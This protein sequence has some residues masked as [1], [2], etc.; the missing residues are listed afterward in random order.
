M[1]QKKVFI[2]KDGV[3]VFVH[4]TESHPHRWDLVEEVVRQITIGDRVFV[5]ETIDLGRI[6]GVDHLVETSEKDEPNIF[7]KERRKG[8]NFKSRMVK[9]R[10]AEPTSLASVIIAKC[11]DNDGPEWTG[12]YVLVTLFEGD[13]GMSE[14]YGRYEH[15]EDCINFWKTHALVPE[16]Q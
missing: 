10:D 16:E 6:I 3:E 15:D 11:D 5:L 7:Y 4:P 2:S 9:N 8:T 12:K 1:E 14:P 13:P